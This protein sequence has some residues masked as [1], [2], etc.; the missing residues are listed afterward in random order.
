MREADFDAFSAMLDDVAGLYPRGAITAGQK[1]M[2][3]RAL[4]A[5]SLPDVRAGF[6]GHVKDPQRGRF[7]PMPADIL[8]QIEG[9]AAN[10]GRP[11][12]EEAWA[13][14]LLATDESRTVVWTDE[15]ASAWGIARP[16]IDSGDQIGA[17]MAFKEAYTR[18]V[19]EARR[20]RRPAT[21]TASLGFDGKQRDAVLQ[22]AQE[23]GRLPAPERIA[24]PAPANAF[25]AIAEAAPPEVLEKL[26]ALRDRLTRAVDVPSIDAAE[27]QRTA[28]LKAAVNQRVDDYQGESA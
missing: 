1:A 9:L 21:W 2:F 12:P 7:L 23:A 8:A 13:T 3:F 28:D 17:R 26:R 27:K 4:A 14:A 5:H 6:D 24:L 16:I 25:E 11:G 18:L 22:A 10:D 20:A 15:A 19:E